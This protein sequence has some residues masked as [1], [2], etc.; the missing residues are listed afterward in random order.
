VIRSNHQNSHAFRAGAL[1]GRM[2]RAAAQQ[3]ASARHWRIDK[4]VSAGVATAALWIIKLTVLAILLYVAFWL[5]L[6]FAVVVI[7]A[8]FVRTT[9]EDSDVEWFPRPTDHRDEL[10]YD[11]LDHNDDPDPRFPGE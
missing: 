1:L 9:H 4:G 8:A 5:A 3:E 10:F 7:A 11:P 2:W 6:V